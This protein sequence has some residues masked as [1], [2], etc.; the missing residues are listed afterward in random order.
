[1]QNG[2]IL[3]RMPF[4]M[5]CRVVKYY[6]KDGRS[7]G[8]VYNKLVSITYVMEKSLTKSQCFIQL[9]TEIF[10]IYKVANKI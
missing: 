3:Y 10:L 8:N 1:M 9:L 6:M 4:F 2:K 5:V 7:R